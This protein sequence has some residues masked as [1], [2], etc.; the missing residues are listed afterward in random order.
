MKPAIS[1]SKYSNRT[2]NM[3]KDKDVNTQ[4]HVKFYE[5]WTFIIIVCIILPISFRAFLYSP[6]HI[7]S[8]SM[9]PTM[10]IGDYIFISKFAYGY[11][12]YS[13]PL[14]SVFSYFDGR[15]GGEEP[16]RGD[17]I[18]FRPPN[19][20]DTDYIKRLVGLPG[21][22]LQMIRGKLWI[23]GVKLKTQRVEDFKD[24]RGE[25]EVNIRRYRETLPNG[26]EYFI[27][28]EKF[29]GPADN[30]EV[31]T[32]PEN[33]YFFMGDNRDNSSDS[34]MSIGFVPKENLVGKAEVIL[35][36]NRSR[37]LE[38]WSWVFSFRG[39][40]FWLDVRDAKE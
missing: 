26:V 24:E 12:K 27:L 40:R 31:F 32:V 23:N 30:T 8:S 17:I 1:R 9:K 13:F 37:F 14:G 25:S 36:S 22:K 39:D 3:K 11:S 7:P 15:I 35:F 16:E 21:D 4:K 33:H 5:T 19:A 6:R 2:K 38:I 10:L 20:T 29:E 18:V 34:R 28:D